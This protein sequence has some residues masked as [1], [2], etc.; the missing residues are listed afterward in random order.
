MSFAALTF[1]EALHVAG[2]FQIGII[3]LPPS[4]VQERSLLLTAAVKHISAR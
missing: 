2:S 3:Q 1:H 4:P